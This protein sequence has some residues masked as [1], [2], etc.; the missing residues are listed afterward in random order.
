MTI[1]KNFLS[2]IM[3]GIYI[4]LGATLYLYIENH[5]I[6]AMFFTLGIFLVSSFYNY[7]FTRVVPLS[8]AT[9]EYNAID[10]AIAY[11]GNFI[12]TFVYAFLLSNTRLANKLKHTIDIVATSKMK[13]SF[14]SLIIM[15]IFCAVMV[16][17]GVLASVKYKDNKIVVLT[18][19]F[20]LVAGFV[21]LGFDHIV[22]NFFYYSFY[23][24][25]F[26]FKLAILPAA[27]AVTIGNLIGGLLIGYLYQIEQKI[28]N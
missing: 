24:L 11:V 14:L 26:G 16:G 10:I 9:K 15:G 19:Y 3:S 18:F 27:L 17:Y 4:S 2:G 1:Q 5:I 13:D 25:L 6:G 8:T 22:A 21:I 7:L 23:S 20:I 28:N 12:G